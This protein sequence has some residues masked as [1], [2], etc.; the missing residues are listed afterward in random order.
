MNLIGNAIKFTRAVRPD[1]V[2]GIA[3]AR[4]CRWF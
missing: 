2:I 1:A 4:R 3:L